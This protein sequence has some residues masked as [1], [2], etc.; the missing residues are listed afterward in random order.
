MKLEL[1]D[2]SNVLQVPTTFEVVQS[3]QAAVD[4][5]A[6]SWPFLREGQHNRLILC[7]NG[8]G[9]RP[10]AEAYAEML[11]KHAA[12]GTT[13]HE[14]SIGSLDESREVDALC[15]TLNVDLLIAIGGGRIIDTA[16]M[17]AFQRKVALLCIPSVLSSDGITSPVS[18]LA[19]GSGRKRSLPSGIPAC[20]VVDLSLTTKAPLHLTKAG[21]G[22]LISNAS[23]LLDAEDY[24]AAGRGIVNGFAKLL[25]YSAFQL[26]KGLIERDIST[27]QG[28]ETIAR[29]LILSGLSMAF[30]GN[31]LPC[32]GAEHLISHALDD[33]NVSTAPHGLKV[34]VATLYCLE[35]RRQ[36]GRASGDPE[37]PSIVANLGLPRRPEDLGVSKDQFIRAVE[38]AP[39]MRPG[40]Y[41]VLHQELDHDLMENAYDRAFV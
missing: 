19:D 38:L 29:G 24:E 10:I 5:I 14:I 32:S 34:A 8:G 36:L 33:M 23:A 40:R 16:K 41:T 9:T 39:E 25:S 6:V 1:S 2:F 30:S 18:V 31:S 4:K 3:S 21:V 27:P 11:G 37:L 15:A 26:T 35:L 20:V 28:Q 12:G 17:V 7:G 13:I 22:D